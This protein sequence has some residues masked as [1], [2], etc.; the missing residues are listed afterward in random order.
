MGAVLQTTTSPPAAASPSVWTTAV[1]VVVVLGII[2]VAG[3]LLTR[4]VRGAVLRAGASKST[5]SSVS[6][7]MGVLM[8]LA[9]VGA[10]TNI[11][12][13]SSYLTALTISGIAGLAVSFALQN[14]ISNVIAG[15]LMHHDGVLRLGDDV[16]YGQGGVRGEVVKL[17]LRTTWLK[18]SDGVVVVLSNSV[19]GSGPV[20]NYSSLPR[21]EKN[22]AA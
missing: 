4:G 6:Q 3:G 5:A 2:A 1:Q 16:Q 21:F 14:T 18:T 8:F 17:S 22:L 10:L 13:L 9:A 20:L 12:G 19:I 15:V 11:E 7:W